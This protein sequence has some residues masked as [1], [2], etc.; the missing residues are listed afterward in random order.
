[1]YGATSG[2]IKGHIAEPFATVCDGNMNLDPA[3]LVEV[4][5]QAGDSGAALVDNQCRVLGTLVGVPTQ[6]PSWRAFSPIAC[7]LNKLSCQIPP[8][9]AT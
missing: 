6:Y 1:M 4:P 5:S 8:G 9:E 7:V 3:I 2:L